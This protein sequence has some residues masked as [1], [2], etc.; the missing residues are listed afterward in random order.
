MTTRSNTVRSSI[1]DD[2]KEGKKIEYI[3]EGGHFSNLQCD[4]QF[5]PK[6]DMWVSNTGL[7]VDKS[8]K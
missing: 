4:Y 3:T 1:L 2:N 7:R 6:T 5:Q 8:V